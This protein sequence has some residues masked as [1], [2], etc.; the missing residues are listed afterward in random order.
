MSL[1]WAASVSFVIREACEDQTVSKFEVVVGCCINYIFRVESFVLD[2]QQQLPVH[3]VFVE[4]SQRFLNVISLFFFFVWGK[5]LNSCPSLFLK[6]ISRDS[7]VFRES[8]ASQR[9]FMGVSR[10]ASIQCWKRCAL[11]SSA[12]FSVAEVNVKQVNLKIYLYML[13]PPHSKYITNII[14]SRPYN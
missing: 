4:G 6:T 9:V 1:R 8:D 7:Y 12:Y 10:R 5:I 2:V 3:G 13:S 11:N 14:N